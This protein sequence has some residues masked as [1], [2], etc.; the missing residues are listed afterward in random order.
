[1]VGERLG[2]VSAADVVAE[3]H[4]LL[5][6]RA[7]EAEGELHV[8]RARPGEH[9]RDRPDDGRVA[10]LARGVAELGLDGVAEAVVHERHALDVGGA[11]R[12]RRGQQRRLEDGHQHAG[13]VERLGDPVVGLDHEVRLLLA[14]EERVAQIVGVEV[15]GGVELIPHPPQHDLVAHAQV[16]VLEE[17]ALALHVHRLRLEA[18]GLDR[19]VARQARQ[20]AERLDLGADRVEVEVGRGHA[21]ELAVRGLELDAEQVLIALDAGGEAHLVVELADALALDAE[22][23]IR[24]DL[25]GEVELQLVGSRAG[26]ARRPGDEERDQEEARVHHE[27]RS[28]KGSGVAGSGEGRISAIR[29]RSS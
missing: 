11:E 16:E 6:E 23:Q 28:S 14:E 25:A 3:R 17:E 20:V 5:A 29:G 7:R 27:S 12:G 2:E 26:G 15:V 8:L 9:R 24:L 22:A 1:V 4:V 10:E 13:H 21:A 19:V 18:E